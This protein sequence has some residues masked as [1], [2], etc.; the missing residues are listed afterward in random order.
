M[1]LHL[2]GVVAGDLGDGLTGFADPAFARCEM[3]CGAAA[4]ENFIVIK[5]RRE[6]RS[7]QTCCCDLLAVSLPNVRMLRHTTG[8]TGVGVKVD[9]GKDSVA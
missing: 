3:Y 2:F 7:F 5:V 4:I 8:F 1:T 9:L 6:V